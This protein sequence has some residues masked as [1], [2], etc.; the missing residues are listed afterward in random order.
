M[1]N[2][3]NPPIE[4]GWRGTLY[5]CDL[6]L[7]QLALVEGE[8]GVA[9]VYPA[10]AMLWQKPEAYQRGVLLYAL[11]QPHVKG[12]TLADCMA[13]IVGEQREYFLVKLQ[14]ATDRLL[15]Q[16]RA[17]WGVTEEAPADPLAVNSGGPNSGQTPESTSESQSQNSGA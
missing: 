11:L 17:I 2:S 12:L 10:P 6:P 16:L 7:G 3:I 1:I 14:K 15:P 5:P 4:V 9:I 13:A 8:V